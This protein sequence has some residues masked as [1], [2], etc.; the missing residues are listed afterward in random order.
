MMLRSV[1]TSID[2]GNG[3]PDHFALNTRERSR[4]MHQFDVQLVMQPENSTMDAVDLDNI[5]VVRH[6]V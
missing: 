3:C 5:V 1:D 4:S 6:T 2:T